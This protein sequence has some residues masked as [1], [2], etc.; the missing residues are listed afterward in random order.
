ML[1][2][3]GV[4]QVPRD[5]IAAKRRDNTMAKGDGTLHITHRA[6]YERGQQDGYGA[7]ITRNRYRPRDG[8]TGTEDQRHA[9][10]LGYGD[11]HAVAIDEWSGE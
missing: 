7:G 8:A 1:P 6:E 4:W 9:Y 3:T 5:K 11:G 2:A 10:M